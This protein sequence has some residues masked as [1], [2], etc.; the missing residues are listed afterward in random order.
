MIVWIT[1]VKVGH[2]QASIPKTPQAAMLGGF[3][4]CGGFSALCEILCLFI[5]LKM[6]FFMD[7]RGRALDNIFVERLW[8]SVKHGKRPANPSSPPLL[9][10]VWVRRRPVEGQQF[11][12]AAIRMRW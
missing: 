7:G 9:Q 8:R 1:H 11:V 4:L 12:D 3:L 6:L 10:R 5:Y 2:R